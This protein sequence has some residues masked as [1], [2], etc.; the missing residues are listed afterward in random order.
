MAKSALDKLKS[1]IK[2]KPNT[3]VGKQKNLDVNKNGKL[4]AADFKM[5]RGNKMAKGGETSKDLD[6][7]LAKIVLNNLIKEKYEFSEIYSLSRFIRENIKNEY[8]ERLPITLA[9]P[10]NYKMS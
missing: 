8:K 4:D 3:L 1:K 9:N 2:L 5:L 6:K 7:K 10:D